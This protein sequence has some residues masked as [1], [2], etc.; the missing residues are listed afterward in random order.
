MSVRVLLI[1]D[2]EDII[3]LITNILEDEDY[4]LIV[5]GDGEEGLAAA[6]AETPDVILL[7]MS[8]PRLSGWDLAPR[9]RAEGIT[10][11]I[12]ALTAHAMRDDRERAL[13]AGCD[14]YLSKPFEIDDLLEALARHTTEG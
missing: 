7:D 8:L 13:A 4:S 9:L 1:E 2:A 5:A 6:R 14:D 10:T 3:R 12:I 11:P